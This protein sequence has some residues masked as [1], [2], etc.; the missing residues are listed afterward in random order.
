MRSPVQKRLKRETLRLLPESDAVGW[1]TQLPIPFTLFL[2][3]HAKGAG[4]AN[5]TLFQHNL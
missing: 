5:Y 4:K 2:N 1:L 3:A